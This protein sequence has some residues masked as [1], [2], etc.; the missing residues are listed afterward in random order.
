MTR[1]NEDITVL[2]WDVSGNRLLIGDAFG[3]VEIWSIKDYLINEWHLLNSFTAFE[4]ERTLSAVWFHNGIKSLIAMDKKDTSYAYS[5]KFINAKFNAS[6]RQFGGKPAQGVIAVSASGLIWCACYLSD[7]SIVTGTKIL[8][9]FRSKLKVVDI[10]YTSDG[11]FLI[12]SSNGSVDSSINCHRV[13]ISLQNSNMGIEKTRCVITSQPFSSFY[14]NCSND[15][16]H[17]NGYSY[18]N[19]LKFILR[20]SADAVVVGA[21]GSLGSTVELWALREKPVQLHKMYQQMKNSTNSNSNNEFNSNSQSNQSTPKTTVWQYSSSANYHQPIVTL[22]TPRVSLYDLNPP[23]SY[24]MVSYRD[25]TVK[26]YYRENLQSIYAI[27]LNSISLKNNPSNKFGMVNMKSTPN[28][29]ISNIV[30]MQF[31][32]SG[33]ALALMDTNSQL[34]VYRVPPVTDPKATFNPVFLQTMLE[35]CLVSGNDWW[36][37][38]ICL[39]PTIIDTLCDMLN[40]GFMQ[41]QTLALQQK[42]YNRFLAIKA[43]LYR[44]LNQGNSGTSGQNKSGDCYTLFMLN[45][46]SHLLKSLL[47]PSVNVDKEG[48]AEMLSNLIQTK[49]NEPH[50]QNVDKVL[51]VLEHKDFYVETS[52]LQSLQH[53]NQW[54]GD[55]ALFLLASLPQQFH[56]HFRF[57][58]VSILQ[59]FNLSSYSKS[60][61]INS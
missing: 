33:F 11:K 20:E 53:L 43:S 27:N 35:Y 34:F 58:G 17:S 2:D 10:C 8:G 51:L 40:D 49:G 55:L 31:S 47:R 46:I 14:L 54:I 4:G 5:E 13:S 52:I 41:R 37:I 44:C 1:H 29:T 38:I 16:V 61:V 26:C 56:N 23:L 19:H 24:I 9:N 36:D 25:N 45:S 21:S 60:A 3:K 30:D 50:Y 7:S 48:P 12:I 22:A 15:V 59:E 42:Y 39:R 32:W 57:P 18:V 6:V 28:P